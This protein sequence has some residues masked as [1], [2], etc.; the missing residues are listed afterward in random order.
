MKTVPTATVGRGRAPW[1]LAAKRHRN[2]GLPAG[3]D[4]LAYHSKDRRVERMS[5][6][7]HP[8]VCPICGHGILAEVVGADT[9]EI[10]L[11]CKPV[12]HRNSGR[13]FYHDTDRNRLFEGLFFSGEFSLRFGN[14]CLAVEDFIHRR[15]HRQEY[16]H[17]MSGR[18]P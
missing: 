18:G 1:T 3:C 11:P 2:T 6:G 17:V 13:N 8:G 12:C 4:R 16:S 7:C 5:Q 14:Q 9:E 10:H 15:D